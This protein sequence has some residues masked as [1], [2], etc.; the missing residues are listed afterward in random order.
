[1][2]LNGVIAFILRF[3]A[4]NSIALQAGYVTVVEDSTI[5]SVKYCLTLPVFYFW[6]KLTHPAAR[7][8]CSS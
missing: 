4:P 2:T 5:V 8:L 3:F 7:S 6:P 1:M